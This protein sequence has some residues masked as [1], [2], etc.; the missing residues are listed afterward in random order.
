MTNREQLIQK[1]EKA[2]D[3]VVQKML[4]FLNQMQPE[5]NAHPLDQ[6][7]GTIN[8]EDAAEMQRAIREDCRQVDKDEW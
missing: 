6:I 3:D 8:D 2:P 4:D 1:L 5:R 7:I